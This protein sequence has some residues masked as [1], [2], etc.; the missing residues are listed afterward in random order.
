[1]TVLVTGAAGFLGSRVVEALLGAAD[2]LPPGAR[3]VAADLAPSGRGDARVTD[4][5][6]SVADAS[7]VREVVTP[8]VAVVF[9]LAASLS[10]QSEAEFDHGMRVNL[11]GTRALLDACRGLPAPPRVVFSSTIAVYGG[12]LPAVV[13]EDMAVRPSSSYGVEKAAAELLVA[14]YARR[15]FVEGVACRVPTVAVRPGAPNSALSSFVSGIV[16][17]PLAGVESV[18]P[19]P[20]DTRLWISS[21]EAVVAN[22]LHAARLPMARYDARPIVNLPG[23]TVTPAEMLAALERVGGAEARA[24]VRLT[25]DDRVS[26]VVCSW[27]GALDVSRSLACGFV[28]D[29]GI[30]A[31]VARFAG[32]RPRVTGGQTP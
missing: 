32:V 28:R 31:I 27:P 15:G 10:G 16:R 22:L 26:R 23:I 8:G 13:P 18:C 2:L 9:H 12:T 5:I 30:D 1:M 17:E 24:R 20:L 21:P 29:D 6:G 4:A 3:V 19:V 11:D 25:P 14:E 7:F